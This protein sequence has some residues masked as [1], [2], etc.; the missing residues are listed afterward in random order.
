MIEWWY[1]HGEKGSTQ[2]SWNLASINVT[3]QIIE[4]KFDLQIYDGF[5]ADFLSTIHVL[6]SFLVYT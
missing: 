4:G 3:M 5:P 1:V 6:Q 2:A